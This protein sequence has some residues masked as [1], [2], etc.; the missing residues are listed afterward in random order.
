MK[1]QPPKQRH[2]HSTGWLTGLLL[3]FLLGTAT[4]SSADTAI[5]GLTGQK[6]VMNSGAEN[7]PLGDSQLANIRG[8]YTPTAAL[9]T[10]SPLAV[11]LWDESVPGQIG[12]SKEL[13]RSS[14]QANQQR[15][16]LQS[17]SAR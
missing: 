5:S 11:I 8:R 1:K 14:G 10:D 16:T 9:E 13:Q 6:S 2:I 12:T 17:N 7:T 15:T 3:I 4:L